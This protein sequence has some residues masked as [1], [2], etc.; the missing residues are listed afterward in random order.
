MLGF[1]SVGFVA[2]IL[3]TL[4]G[5]IIQSAASFRAQAAQLGSLR[6]MGLSGLSVGVYLFLLQTLMTGSGIL[7]GTSIGVAT[8]LLYLPLL[9]FSGGLPPY[10]VRVAWGNIVLVY[11]AFA[12]ILLAVTFGTTAFLGRER[13]STLVKLGDA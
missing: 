6:A 11:A 3:L 2:S 5:A 12:A 8:T 1:L 13:L 4:V 7:S 9:D 10:L